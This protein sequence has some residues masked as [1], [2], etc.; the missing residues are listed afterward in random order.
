V[1]TALLVIAATPSIA[2]ADGPEGAFVGASVGQNNGSAWVF[3]PEE[4]GYPQLTVELSE[5]TWRVFGGYR[6]RQAG[7][8]CGYR[9]LGT[10]E[11]TV[12][13]FP[14][15]VS[16]K[17]WDAFAVGL[18]PLGRLE[19]FGKLGMYFHDL[20]RSDP[21][22][23]SAYVISGLNTPIGAVGVS[24]RWPAVSLRLEWERSFDAEYVSAVSVGVVLHL[25]RP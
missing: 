8:E 9:D 17:G 12:E 18:V 16:S 10:A 22:S 11:D 3:G 5:T 24:V 20:E 7:V 14:V 21:S 25:T 13:G 1:A 6:W 4:S 2:G 23:P 15:S 19:L